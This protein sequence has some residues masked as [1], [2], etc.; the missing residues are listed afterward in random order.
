V[1]I[2]KSI[3]SGNHYE[4][5]FQQG[6]QHRRSIQRVIKDL[7]ESDVVN[8]NKPKF[9]PRRLFFALAKQ[10][11]KKLL[12]KDIIEAYPKQAE[13]LRG[14]SDGASLGLSSILFIQMME[15]L[16]GCTSLAFS[17]K[18]VIQVSLSSRKILIT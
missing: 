2:D 8:D 18:R 11:A 7:L 15:I 12:K 17:S 9:L 5:G 10:R 1:A 14:I 6:K 3:F 4:M 16:V 13:R